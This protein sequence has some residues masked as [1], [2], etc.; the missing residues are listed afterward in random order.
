[1]LKNV[2]KNVDAKND[3]ILIVNSPVRNGRGMN[4]NVIYPYV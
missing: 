3:C 4:S 1:M 2:N